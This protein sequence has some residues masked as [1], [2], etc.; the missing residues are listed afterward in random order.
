MPPVPSVERGR[1]LSGCEGRADLRS[2][3]LDQP[4]MLRGECILMKLLLKC[5]FLIGVVYGG[6]WTGYH[7]GEIDALTWARKVSA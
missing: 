3:S 2:A 5:V 6:Y 7:H 1:A 4:G